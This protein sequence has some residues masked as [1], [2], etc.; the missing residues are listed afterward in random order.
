MSEPRRSRS[1]SLANRPRRTQLAR[2]SAPSLSSILIRPNLTSLSVDDARFEI[3]NGVLKLKDGIS[4]NFEAEPLVSVAVTATDPEGLSVSQAF[5][6]AVADVNEQADY[7]GVTNNHVNENAPGAIIGTLFSVN[8]PDANETTSFESFDSRFEVIDGVLKLK[9][10]VSLDHETL[11]FL[12]INIRSTDSG[13]NQIT[14]QFEIRV[15]DL[16]Q[17]PSDI[18]VTPI[19]AGEIVVSDP[20]PQYQSRLTLLDNGNYVLLYV[21]QNTGPYGQLFDSDGSA[22]GEPFGLPG[23]G[24]V[25]DAAPLPGGGFA[26]IA[27]GAHV[28]L[29]ASDGTPVGPATVNGQSPGSSSIFAL[30]GG[31]FVAVWD[32]SDRDGSS[33]GVFAQRYD[34][35]GQ[36]AGSEFQVNTSALGAQQNNSSGGV[37][38]GAGEFAIFW[39]SSNPTNSIVGQRFDATGAPIGGEVAMAIGAST[40]IQQ[41]ILLEGGNVLV[42]W[43]AYGVDGSGYGAIWS[44]L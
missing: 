10:G 3:V 26:V 18:D 38:L 21:D 11:P 17:S 39:Q 22:I 28:A 42:T 7:L 4:L 19:P 9:D 27:A 37:D 13:G 34:S 43:L 31:G 23:T 1:S 33:Y 41:T 12:N 35:N 44:H 14:Q 15:D 36:K 40:A 32:N 29:F 5:E 2:S 8:D 24:S 25:P 6:I 30:A 20:G 16:N